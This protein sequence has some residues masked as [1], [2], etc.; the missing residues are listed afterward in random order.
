MCMSRS[1]HALS[2]QRFVLNILRS[3]VG[4]SGWV[5]PKVGVSEFDVVNTQTIA[6]CSS[7]LTCWLLLA[8]QFLTCSLN[9]YTIFSAASQD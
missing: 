5:D 4:Y 8:L 9:C 2:V 6:F 3:G 7:F 1:L